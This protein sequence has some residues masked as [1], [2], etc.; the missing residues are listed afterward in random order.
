MIT[1]SENH[2]LYSLGHCLYSL[3]EEEENIQDLVDD[4]HIFPGSVTYQ[5]D[6]VHQKLFLFMICCKLN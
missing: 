1:K 6:F 2:C 3:G 4:M 5:Q